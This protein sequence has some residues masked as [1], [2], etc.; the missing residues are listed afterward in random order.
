MLL[1][2][3]RSEA[4]WI[5]RP[6]PASAHVTTTMG[7]IGAVRRWT[8]CSSRSPAPR[9]RTASF[10]IDSDAAAEAREAALALKARHDRRQ[11]DVLR[12]R[13]G[14]RAVRRRP[15]RHDQ[16][17]LEARAYG[18]ARAFGPLLVNT[19]VGFIGPEYLFDG[20]QI[21]RAGLDDISAASCS[22][23]RWAAIFATQPRRGRSGR[24]GCPA[25]LA[26]R[27]GRNFVM[28]VPGADDIMLAIR[29][30]RFTMRWR[31]ASCWV[32]PAPDSRLATSARSAGPAGRAHPAALPGRLRRGCWMAEPPAS[33]RPWRRWRFDARRASALN[34]RRGLAGDRAVARAPWPR[35]GARRGPHRSRRPRLPTISPGRCPAVAGARPET[36]GAICCGP[37]WDAD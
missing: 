25:H 36:G 21:I 15:S 16:Q 29:A 10:G 35:A 8:W 17:T 7:L 30:R 28:G 9:R 12:D 31:C 18:V 34:A 33:L 32:S 19:V 5:S 37:I 13:P 4:G 23:C 24:H 26:G 11:R 1:A 27:G 3:W 14:Q 2:F 22:A 20:K 6:S